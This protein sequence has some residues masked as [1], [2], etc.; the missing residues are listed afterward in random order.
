MLSLKVAIAQWVSDPA[1]NTPICTDYHNQDVV[2]GVSDGAGGMILTWR[3]QEMNYG[4]DVYA[5]RVNSEGV[6]QW[7]L[8]GI[9]IAVYEG[10]VQQATSIIS[11]GNGG[12]YIGWYDL[13]AN[14]QD[15]F[16]LP[17]SSDAYIQHVASSGEVLWGENGMSISSVDTAREHDPYLVDDGLGGVLVFWG[18]DTTAPN[19]E[20]ITNI[21]GQKY[22]SAGEKL[23]GDSGTEIALGSE[24]LVNNPNYH[25]KVVTNG[26]GG[27]YV[28]VGSQNSSANTIIH[29]SAEGEVLWTIPTPRVMQLV[30]DN[31]GGVTY[32]YETSV[33]ADTAWV[34]S[35]HAQRINGEAEFLWGEEGTIFLVTNDDNKF[36][37]ITPNSDGG[38][39][40]FYNTTHAA[41]IYC[42]RIDFGGVLEWDQPVQIASDG[43]YGIEGL[44][45]DPSDNATV[46][47]S[48]YQD[49]SE[50]AFIKAQRISLEG[51]KI[52]GDNGS[53]ISTRET[54]KGYSV[55]LVNGVGNGHIIVWADLHPWEGWDLYGQYVNQYGNIGP[56]SISNEKRE[57]PP[58]SATL[59][60]YPNPF[61][62]RTTIEYIV[63]KRSEVTLNIFDIR[64]RNILTLVNKSQQAGMYRMS[65][66]GTD[67]RGRQ[68]AS[69]KY[70]IKIQAGDYSQTIDIVYL[71]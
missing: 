59:S 11:D 46:V 61:N 18:A 41:D 64:G 5:Q 22:N 24:D 31:N 28:F 67:I 30:S 1:I 23:W 50:I 40:V 56:T 69:G 20:Y 3:D 37:E 15:P 62:P 71:R 43:L 29:V 9:P 53:F 13:R 6:V 19:G 60:A 26:T 45:S 51:Y 8:R 65:W 10:S 34:Y 49:D 55:P 63:L 52:W 2:L 4:Y 42:Q 27:G 54:A 48:D 57:I 36:P 12:A 32:S 21:Y 7:A 38:V 35:H 44:V 25:I 68:L 17:D 70:F 39:Y 33:Y 66:D 16:H 47:F 58:Q 14:T